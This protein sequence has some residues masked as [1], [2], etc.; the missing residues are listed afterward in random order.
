MVKPAKTSIKTQRLREKI[1]SEVKYSKQTTLGMQQEPQKE[2]AKESVL[3]RKK[4]IEITE[5]CPSIRENELVLKVAFKLLP[6]RTSFSRVTSDLLF[7]DEKIDS[8]RLRIL[9]GPL[10]SNELEFSSVLD[11]TGIVE[12]QHSLRID[13]YELWSSGEKLTCTSKEL[14]VNYVPIKKEDRLVKVP[15]VKSVAGADLSIVSDS[16]KEIYREID[17]EMKKDLTSR[18]DNW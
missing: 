6:S 16:Q 3:E 17:D 14:S 10:A 12:G 4:Q 1:R 15:M 18:R 5:V 13:M 8:M 9:Q 7:D 2:P 11:M